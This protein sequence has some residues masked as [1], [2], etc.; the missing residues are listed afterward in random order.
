MT[1]NLPNPRISIPRIP[2]PRISAAAVP[3]AVTSAASDSPAGRLVQQAR[4]LIAGGFRNLLSGESDGQP[5]WVRQLGDG[6]DDGYFGPGSATWAV[7]G[8]LPT[9]VGGVRALLLQTLHPAALA[10]VMQHSRYEED[11]LG[12]LIGTTRWLTVTTF[13]DMAMA[14]R[15]CARVRGMHKKVRGTYDEHGASAVYSASDPELLRWVHVAF[16]DS[17]LSAHRVWGG[18]IPGGED[19]YV[20]EWAKAG[21]LVGLADPPRS[22]AE[23]ADQ[24]ASFDHILT[25]GDATAKTVSFIRNPPLPLP[26]RPPYGVL[27]AGAVAS[28]PPRYRSMLGVPTVPMP[29]AKPAVSS[30]LGAL[31]LVLGPQSPSMRNA[32]ARSNGLDTQGS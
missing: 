22:A 4:E 12:R 5:D 14:D 30:M 11:A 21:E 1:P 3:S 27:F 28:L 7:H 16:T 17:F 26:A 10:G 20:A 2:T 24:L 32:Q 19:Q 29:I 9:L 15:E 18:E 25:G 8:S 6:T 13:G 31:A 23:L